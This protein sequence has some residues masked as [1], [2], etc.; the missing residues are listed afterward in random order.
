[1][2]AHSVRNDKG[3]VGERSRSK[4]RPLHGSLN[5]R[6]IDCT[7]WD[8]GA[9]GDGDGTE[10]FDQ[11]ESEGVGVVGEQAFAVFIIERVIDVGFQI[12]L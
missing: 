12:K 1:M 2:L 7:G 10:F 5:P 3:V 9:G 4:D 8:A 11:A 6:E